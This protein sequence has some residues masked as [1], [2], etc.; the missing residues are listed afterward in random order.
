MLPGETFS[1]Y[2]AKVTMAIAHHVAKPQPPFHDPAVQACCLLNGLSQ[3][4][5]WV[6]F[7]AKYRDFINT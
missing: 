1:H 4:E 5:P 2:L 3:E 7:N 6:S